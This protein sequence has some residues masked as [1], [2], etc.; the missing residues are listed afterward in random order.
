MTEGKENEILRTGVDGK[1][2]KPTKIDEQT[3]YMVDPLLTRMSLSAS[4][5]GDCC[6]PDI[7]SSSLV[8][9]I[10][11]GSP[12]VTPSGEVILGARGRARTAGAGEAALMTMVA[13][14]ET[15]EVDGAAVSGARRGEGT[16]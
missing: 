5:L 10:C 15:E 12:A 9:E 11:V 16:R 4:F 1:G 2:K 14:T 13:G 7:N 3:S 6:F 8:A